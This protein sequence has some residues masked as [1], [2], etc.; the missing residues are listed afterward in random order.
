MPLS[1]T[2][3]GVT[4]ADHEDGSAMLERLVKARKAVPRSMKPSVKKCHTSTVT[5]RKSIGIRAC[6]RL[7]FGV[8]TCRLG[9]S[10]GARRSSHL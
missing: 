3:Q 7:S 9:C 8:F 2:S 10:D 4:V 5:N 6:T 1:S